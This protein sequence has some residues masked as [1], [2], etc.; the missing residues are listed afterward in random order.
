MIE[1]KKKGYYN[2]Y[3]MILGTRKNYKP[4]QYEWAYNL[5][6]KHEKMHWLPTEVPMA[7]DIRDYNTRL[8]SGEKN[9]LIQI[10]RFFTQGDL[11]VQNNYNNQL[12][13][14]FRLPEITMMLSSFAARE[15][16]HVW[17][18]SHLNDTLGLPENEYSKFLEYEEMRKKIDKMH[19]YSS[20]ASVSDM[21]LALNLAVFG[22]FIEGV[23]L[24]GS[25]AVLLNFS[26]RGLMKGV[27]QI[28]A[29]SAEDESIHSQGVSTLFKTLVQEAS[30]PLPTKVIGVSTPFKTL[31]QKSDI[32]LE[33]L[34]D[35]VYTACIDIVNAEKEFLKLCFA[36]GD[37]IGLKL[38]DACK[39]IEYLADMR[40]RGL[41]YEPI[42]KVNS[43]PLRYMDTMLSAK[44]HTNFFENRATEYAKGAINW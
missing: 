41:G 14:N 27:G 36:D 25:F 21:A 12:I 17:A 19:Y 24:F 3:T 40:L 35:R 4:I 34:A 32:N 30:N 22:G 7:D 20:G 18:Y 16:I 29:W 15:N 5:F 8:T 1:N 33:V 38:E 42:F 10:L 6:E 2:I 31:V 39:Y 44:E 26:R 9:L 43:N 13:H 23:S 11:E 37:V 28:V